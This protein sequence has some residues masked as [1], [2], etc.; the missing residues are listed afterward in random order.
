MPRSRSQSTSSLPGNLMASWSIQS[1]PASRVENVVEDLPSEIPYLTVRQT[2]SEQ[3]TEEVAPLGI[4]V[5][6]ALEFMPDPAMPSL[7]YIPRVLVDGTITQG[8]RF[9]SSASSQ[10][11]LMLPPMPP[12]S[13]MEHLPPFQYLPSDFISEINHNFEDSWGTPVSNFTSIHDSECITGA[14][15]VPEHYP[16]TNFKPAL[17]AEIGRAHV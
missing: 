1:Y 15:L 13:L 2:M 8:D 3:P 4:P 7:H 9:L 5:S 16:P 17:P 10:Y 12:P 6:N 11:P 14:H